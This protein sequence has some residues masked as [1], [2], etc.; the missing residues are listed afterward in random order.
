[1]QIHS[2]TLSRLDNSLEQLSLVNDYSFII[3]KGCKSEA[4]KREAQRMMSKKASNVSF[5]CKIPSGHTSVCQNTEDA[6]RHRSSPELQYPEIL[7]G[8]HYVGR[9]VESLPLSW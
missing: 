5:K 7:L 9:L 6:A 2:L 4:A 1:M 8:F 3:A